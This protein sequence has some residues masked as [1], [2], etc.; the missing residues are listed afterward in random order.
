MVDVG[1]QNEAMREADP[2]T[3]RC[4][5]EREAMGRAGQPRSVVASTADGEPPDSGA[6]VDSRGADRG[7]PGVLGWQP[8]LHAQRLGDG[9]RGANNACHGR[10]SDVGG[11]DDDDDD[12]RGDEHERGAGYQ[13]ERDVDEHDRGVDDADG[14]HR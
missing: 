3:L 11:A 5:R 10:D 8:R 13:R 12:E 14:D 2:E 1:P 7:S 4:A 9:E 6:K